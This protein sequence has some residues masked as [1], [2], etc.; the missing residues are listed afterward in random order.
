MR[1]EIDGASESWKMDSVQLLGFWWKGSVGL[2]ILNVLKSVT[3]KV[4]LQSQSE[5]LK[6]LLVNQRIE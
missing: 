4:Y 6:V 1:E 3:W 5:F 2:A